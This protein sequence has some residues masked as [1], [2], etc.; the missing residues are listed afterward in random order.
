MKESFTTVN[1]LRL[2]YLEWG[3]ASAPSILL[4]HGFSSTALAWSNVG[5]ALAGRYHVV[6]LDQRGHGA[7]DWDPRGRYAYDDFVADARAVSQEMNLAPF[8]LVG[9]S[10]GGSIAY[11]YASVYPE[12][13]S[14]L[15]VEDSAPRPAND[16]RPRPQPMQAPVFASRDEVA[17]SVREANPHMSPEAVQR[18]VDVY[19]IQRPD[20]TWGY[21]ADVAG[22]R[23]A[24]VGQPGYEKLWQHVRNIKCPTLVIRAGQ[25]PPGI[26]LETVDLLKQA[27]PRI[28]VVTVPD[29]AHNIHFAHFEA[30][31]PLLERFLVEPAPVAAAP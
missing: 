5:E 6:A 9:H 16:P 15:V 19:Y 17:A 8:V 20:G 28:E 10:M 25:E 2:R 4:L 22:V 18:R 14:R 26:T 27:N 21:R 12:D 1:G 7:S 30:F 29:A 13:L 23:N 3:T 24:Q 11:T 31:M